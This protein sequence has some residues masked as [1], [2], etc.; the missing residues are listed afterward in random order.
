MSSRSIRKQV[1][2]TVCKQVPYTV[3]EQVPVTT[4]TMV[5]EE[6]VKQVPGDRPAGW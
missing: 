4:C 1:P 2:V 6:Q 3:T 5:A